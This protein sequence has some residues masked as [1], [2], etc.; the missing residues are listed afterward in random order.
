MDPR[1]LLASALLGLTIL[2]SACG[3][4]DP[5]AP[6]EPGPAAVVLSP[7]GGTVAATADDGTR[8]TLE[9]PAG[10]V[11]EDT[12]FELVAQE[13]GPDEWA[14]FSITPAAFF[15]QPITVTLE[16]P[17]GWAAGTRPRLSLDGSVLDTTYDGTRTLIAATH[18]LGYDPDDGL[19]LRASSA[20]GELVAADLDCADL[21]QALND[22]ITAAQAGGTMDEELFKQLAT[23]FGVLATDCPELAPS[24]QQLESALQQLACAEYDAAVANLQE[25][26]PPSTAQEIQTKVDR[27]VA[28]QG[29]KLETDADCGSGQDFLDAIEPI[30][31]AYVEG[32]QE[33]FG[34]PDY[35]M[36]L[37]TWD[38]L[39]Q[40]LQAVLAV[41]AQ[42]A[43][44]SLTDMAAGIES[45]VMVP[46]MTLFRDKA[47]RMCFGPEG[48]HAFLGDLR[49]AGA[50]MDHAIGETLPTFVPFDEADLE[51]DIQ[52]CASNLE[53]QVLDGSGVLLESMQLQ[54]D[55]LDYQVEDEAS[56]TVPG[57]GTI[58][59]GGMLR[60]LRC[61]D[62]APFP[63][64][65]EIR[66]DFDVL[67]TLE[68]TPQGVLLDD[69]YSVDVAT[70]IEQLQLGSGGTFDL[71]LRRLDA[72]DDFLGMSDTFP[73]FTLEVTTEECPPGQKG[74]ELDQVFATTQAEV[75]ALAGVVRLD[76]LYIGGGEPSDI[77]DLSPL[78][79]LEAVE[80]WLQI[81]NNPLLESLTGLESLR[82]VGTLDI[83]ANDGLTDLNGLGGLEAARAINISAAGLTT[84]Q[85]LTFPVDDPEFDFRLYTPQVTD[86]GALSSLVTAR[87]LHLEVGAGTLAGLTSLAGVGS[88]EIQNCPNL[89]S[90]DGVLELALTSLRIQ[91][92]PALTS[93]AALSGSTWGEAA[94]QAIRIQ[95]NPTLQSLEGLEDLEVAWDFSIEG[96]DSLTDLTGLENLEAVTHVFGISN[97]QNLTSLDG[98]TSL[99]DGSLRLVLQGNPSLAD[100]S[101]LGNLA[102]QDLELEFV[103]L[104]QLTSLSGLQGLTMEK[105]TVSRCDGMQSLG[106]SNCV[107]TE[108]IQIWSNE[109]LLGIDGLEPTSS[110]TGSLKIMEN[111]VLVDLGGLSGLQSVGGDLWIQANDSLDNCLAQT[112]AEAIAV[113]G[114]TA[115]GPNGPCEGE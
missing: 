31:T 94:G 109:S 83:Q 3:G 91:G 26:E 14:R 101:A 10:A 67:A 28:A 65:L 80:S 71:Q 115:V 41:A 89:T 52:Y 20:S 42:A 55:I 34:D 88:L 15:V 12:R 85:G 74:C 27:V 77:H 59:L 23:G 108:D 45:D 36:E 75:D 56:L 8:L 111:P 57:D 96:N 30:F 95:D 43:C 50:L 69:P 13:P 4:D 29:L 105:L 48:T 17:A 32:K 2:S 19:V 107:V 47:Y 11:L 87:S 112:F 92:N 35:V 51:R 104:P 113:S 37:D 90:L 63:D 84:L 49:A 103:D 81:S 5:V 58:E 53:I 99:V 21:A 79:D 70:V 40:E 76:Q 61:F 66:A 62:V 100:I 60:A 93:I 44:F 16:M 18:Y 38:G 7:A 114:G 102:N 72:C 9:V 68:P 25:G 98:L 6:S 106:M 78:S 64:E 46:L 73:L 86:L 54:Q 1:T 33:E 39:W 82:E 110:L 22:K 24:V 97:N